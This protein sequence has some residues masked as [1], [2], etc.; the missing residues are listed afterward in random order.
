MMHSWNIT[1]ISRARWR[2]PRRVTDNPGSA[3]RVV[4]KKVQGH[5]PG[6]TTVRGGAICPGTGPMTMFSSAVMH[7]HGGGFEGATP[8]IWQSSWNKYHSPQDGKSETSLVAR[9]STTSVVPCAHVH[10]ASRT[11]RMKIGVWTPKITGANLANPRCCRVGKHGAADDADLP[12]GSGS[13]ACHFSLCLL[14]GP[15][16][17]RHLCASIFLGLIAARSRSRRHC[18]CVRVHPGDG[19]VLDARCSLAQDLQPSRTSR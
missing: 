14:C 11:L 10:R 15:K 8:P 3:S 1:C 16:S 13:S 18:P 7:P 9:C 19:H 6:T 5:V 12:R 2:A 17:G 4:H